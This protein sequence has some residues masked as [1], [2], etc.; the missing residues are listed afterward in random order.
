[1]KTFGYQALTDGASLRPQ[2]GLRE[3]G[4]IK[5]V[6]ALSV[7]SFLH[8]D[9]LYSIATRSHSTRC[10]R[11]LYEPFGSWWSTVCFYGGLGD[12]GLSLA[13]HIEQYTKRQL[14]HQSDALNALQGIFERY[15]RRGSPVSQ[16]WGIPTVFTAYQFVSWK[17]SCVSKGSQQSLAS[18]QIHAAFA[19]GLL[20][21][22]GKNACAQRRSGFPSW[23]WAGWITSVSWPPW[24][25]ERVLEDEIF[26]RISVANVT[27]EEEPLADAFVRAYNSQAPSSLRYIPTLR[28][29][30]EILRLRFSLSSSSRGCYHSTTCRAEEPIFYHGGEQPRCEVHRCP[31]D[32]TTSGCFGSLLTSRKAMNC[33][34]H[35]ATKICHASSLKVALLSLFGKK[36]ESASSHLS[37]PVHLAQVLP[38]Y[39]TEPHLVR[40]IIAMILN[41]IRLFRSRT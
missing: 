22:L 24:D 32:A 37:H 41:S 19:F 13:T 8:P 31:S 4:L 35:Y 33:G 6:S 36:E 12:P 20:W 26:I 7:G 17:R 15:T 2:H 39:M 9:K 28:I 18:S 30:A 27:G 29:D 38:R 25:D 40:I 3:L 5:R 34:V 23:S 21:R 1:M 10:M 16:Y 14:S 11:P